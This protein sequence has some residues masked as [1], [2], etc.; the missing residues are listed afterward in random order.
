[1]RRSAAEALGRLGCQPAAAP[2]RAA[3]DAETDSHALADELIALVQLKHGDA[4]KLCV[5]YLA[6]RDPFVRG[7]AARAEALRAPPPKPQ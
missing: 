4:E 7:E 6:D 2:L 3:L 1:M 5:R